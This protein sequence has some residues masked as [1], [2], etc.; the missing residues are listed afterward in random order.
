MRPQLEKLE[1][2]NASATLAFSQYGYLSAPDLSGVVQ[3]DQATYSLVTNDPVILYTPGYAQAEF[4][5]NS[6]VVLFAGY[7][8]SISS[9]QIHVYCTGG[10]ASWV[11]G[12]GSE[13]ISDVSQSYVSFSGKNYLC[14]VGFD[15]VTADAGLGADTYYLYGSRLNESVSLAA[16]TVSNKHRDGVNTLRGIDKAVLNGGGGADLLSSALWPGSFQVGF[17]SEGQ[18]RSMSIRSLVELSSTIPG[19]SFSRARGLRD[20]V[21]SQIGIGRNS[22]S[23]PNR[24]LFDRFFDVFVSRT[25]SVICGGAAI[26]LADLY[27]VFGMPSR[28]V[29]LWEASLQNSHVSTEVM[30]GGNWIAQDPTYNFVLK[31]T[32]GNYLSYEGARAESFLLDTESMGFRWRF[33]YL[34]Y[35]VPYHSYFAWILYTPQKPSA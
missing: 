9:P 5:Q 20:Y 10:P 28:K 27:L 7:S 13:T 18:L 15:F 17:R 16:N 26:L 31:G 35:P 6:G 29:Y 33:N 14:F 12:D 24:S 25:E 34:I 3:K 8:V 30:I 11:G 2:R 1:D 4:R 21:N 22:A 19:E 32:S 23:W